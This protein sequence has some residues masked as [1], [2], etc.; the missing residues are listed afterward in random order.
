MNTSSIGIAHGL[1]TM[2]LI[3]VACVTTQASELNKNSLEHALRSTKTPAEV[4]TAIKDLGAYTGADKAKVLAKRIGKDNVT[5]FLLTAKEGSLKGKDLRIKGN[6]SERA[7]TMMKK[8][9]KDWCFVTMNDIQ[10]LA[11]GSKTGSFF[12]N[13]ECLRG[14]FVFEMDD[15]G[16]VTK[17][18]IPRLGSRTMKGAKTIFS[19][20]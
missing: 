12:V 16:N 11:V 8:L 20:K 15:Q 2:I 14:F 5:Y 6:A 1:I 7:M 9:A 4:Q 3:G 17:L 18:A 13:N 19:K 10:N